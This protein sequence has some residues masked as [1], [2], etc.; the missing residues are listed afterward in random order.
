MSNC[1]AHGLPQPCVMCREQASI[2]NSEPLPGVDL[3]LRYSQDLARVTAQRDALREACEMMAA[4][5]YFGRRCPVIM[6]VVK[7]A[8]ALCREGGT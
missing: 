1:T 4:E 2:K 7:D 5:P 8:L 6:Q 3:A